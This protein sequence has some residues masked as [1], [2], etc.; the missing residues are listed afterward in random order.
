MKRWGHLTV[1]DMTRREIRTVLDEIA[2][3]APIMANRTLA[4]V[5]KIFNFA[6]ER[7]WLEANPCQMIK[8]LAPE[9]QRDRVLSE[10]EIRAVWKGLDSEDAIIAGV[11]RLRLLTAQRGGE[12]LG[13][14]WDEMDLASG[15]WTIPARGART[16]W[17]TAFRSLHRPSIW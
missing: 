5:R 14:A 17:R 15:W 10:D 6:I 2:E 8:R 12:V 1:K 11:F 13:A 3:R 4:L 16:A 7:D 9:K